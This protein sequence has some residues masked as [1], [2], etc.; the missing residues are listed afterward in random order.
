MKS[1]YALENILEITSKN[2]KLIEASNLTLFENVTTLILIRTKSLNDEYKHHFLKIKDERVAQFAW[3]T[4]P[5]WDRIS[6]WTE[7]DD[8]RNNVLAH[9]LRTEK[10]N[11]YQSIFTL[12]SFTDFDIPKSA[13][14]LAV[15]VHCIDQFRRELLSTFKKEYENAANFIENIILDPAT[16]DCNFLK[17]VNNLNQL[18]HERKIQRP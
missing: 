8:F 12:K 2:T 15:L 11:N 14:E 5:I 13:N 16:K 4:Q 3:A 18:L 1:L 17:E 10:R 6:Q 9:N 7:I